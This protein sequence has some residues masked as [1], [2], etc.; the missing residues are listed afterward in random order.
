M[1]L[2][3]GELIVV[4]AGDDVSLP[5]RT[6][7]IHRAWEESGRR[8]TSIFSCYTT[9]NQDGTVRGIGGKRESPV[10]GTPFRELQGGLFEFLSAKKPVVNGCTHA[11]S[12]A[13]YEFFG[14]LTA[15]L[16]DLVLSFRTLA[17]G[18][19]LYIDQPLVKYRRHEANVSFFAE[20]EANPSFAHRENRLRWVDEK[21]VTAYDNMLADIDT[22]WKKGR[23]SSD[24]RERLRVEARRIRTYFAVERQM[25][26]G[27]LAQR[28][29]TLARNLRQGH[30][31]A[32]LRFST[33][34]LPRPLYRSLFLLRE[35]W[36]SVTDRSR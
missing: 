4:G 32:A 21:N 35:R 33:R 36:Q 34:G 3:R 1:E 26:D 22:L 29:M 14:P 17:I 6:E 7:V 10:N 13:L 15:D 16:E 30:V 8:A 28:W 18:A 11:W 9:I 12:P 19:L 5:N 25:M 23:L 27:N 24:E 2:C 20:R 31:R